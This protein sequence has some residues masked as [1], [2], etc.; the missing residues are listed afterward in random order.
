VPV[1]LAP[2][3]DGQEVVEDYRSVGLSLRSHPVAFLRTTLQARGMVTCADLAHVRDGQRVVVPGIVL[4][5]QKPGSAKGVMFI[6]IEDETGVANLILW[7]DRYAEQ[8]RLVLTAGM[9]ACHGRVQREGEVTHVITDRLE[10]LSNL[11]RSVGGRDEALPVQHG[12]GDGATHPA[13]P[14]LRREQGAGTGDRTAQTVAS[15]DLQL[16]AGIRCRPGISA[17]EC[18]PDHSHFG[19]GS[20]PVRAHNSALSRPTLWGSPAIGVDAC[21]AAPSWLGRR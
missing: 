13:G 4:V 21:P 14:D 20:S 9:L 11:L 5:R 16:G 18:D 2:M 17:S 1:P 19:A 7:P 6:T 8:R 15:T 10:D 12:R 3:R